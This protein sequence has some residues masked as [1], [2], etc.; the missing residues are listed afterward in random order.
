VGAGVSD[1]VLQLSE[2]G[3]NDLLEVAV[4]TDESGVCSSEQLKQ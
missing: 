4:V 2:L 1:V 3:E